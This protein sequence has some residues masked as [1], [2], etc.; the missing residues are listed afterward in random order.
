MLVLRKTA[1]YSLQVLPTLLTGFARMLHVESRP[2]ALTCTVCTVFCGVDSQYAVVCICVLCCECSSALEP[3]ASLG[4]CAHALRDLLLLTSDSIV[5][6]CNLPLTFTMPA[7]NMPSSVVV[8]QCLHTLSAKVSCALK[9][10][11]L[12]TF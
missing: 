10:V 3:A 12:F 5:R 4:H 9:A 11:P 1:W 7:I 6:T 8:Q 2:W